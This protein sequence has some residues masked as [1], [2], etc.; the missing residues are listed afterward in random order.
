MEV[1]LTGRRVSAQEAFQWGLV[2]ELTTPENLLSR[3]KALLTELSQYGAV[4]LQGVM[5]TI[6]QG[7]DLALPQALELEAAH[8]AICC[9]TADKR[10]GVNAFIEKRTAVFCGE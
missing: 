9:T 3:A 5:S 6:E 2:N 1:C 8:F 4:A 7:Y 10:E